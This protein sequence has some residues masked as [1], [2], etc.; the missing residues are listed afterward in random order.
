MNS[1]AEALWAAVLANPEDDAPRLVYADWLDEHGQP[2]RAAFIRLQIEWARAPK[3][4]PI[5]VVLARRADRLWDLYGA[6]W[7]AE[8]PRIDHITW[9][10]FDRGF[11]RA[12]VAR[13][14]ADFE[15]VAAQL[16]AIAPIDTLE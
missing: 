16:S 14:L 11:P 13:S 7:V 12:V 6:D 5:R 3:H 2:E 8:L 1:D 10:E 4:D 9:G 15:R